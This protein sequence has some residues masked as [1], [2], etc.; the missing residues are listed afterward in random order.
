MQMTNEYNSSNTFV[1][2]PYKALGFHIG[3]HVAHHIR[4]DLHWSLLPEYHESIKDKIP[5]E[6]Y[7]PY[8]HASDTVVAP[9]VLPVQDAVIPKPA[10]LVSESKV[11]L[12]N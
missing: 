1:N 11:D 10:A 5:N 7:R 9:T 3:Y 8:Q 6:N 2:L 4:P 12:T